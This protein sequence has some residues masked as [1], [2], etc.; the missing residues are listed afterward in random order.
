MSLLGC[1]YWSLWWRW[2]CTVSLLTEGPTCE[3]LG[4]FWMLVCGDYV[5]C[6]LSV[7]SFL[8][9]RKSCSF[10]SSLLLQ[11]TRNITPHSL[12]YVWPLTHPRCCAGV[13]PLPPSWW[14]WVLLPPSSPSPKMPQTPSSH[15]AP[16]WTEGTQTGLLAA[17]PMPSLDIVMSNT[18]YFWITNFRSI[19]WIKAP[20]SCHS[21]ISSINTMYSS[22]VTTIT[23]HCQRPLQVPSWCPECHGC[24]RPGI[25]HV[26]H[27]R[28]AALWRP[29]ELLF[30]RIHPQPWGLQ[31]G[32]LWTWDGSFL[33]WQFSSY[34]QIQS[35]YSVLGLTIK[36][37]F[38]NEEGS[39]VTRTWETYEANFDTFF[40][41][42]LTLLEV[43]TFEGAMP[44]I[45]SATDATV[46]GW[47][48][49]D[50]EDRKL[51][52]LQLM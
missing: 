44:I 26:R 5:L 25:F 49:V 38:A 30:W 34:F 18:K 51:I 17:M 10:A 27:P 3:T 28:H 19:P 1:S 14:W 32:R 20:F 39:N 23:A 46:G 22:A 37:F 29:A 48:W 16:P 43:S 7:F 9:F 52:L 21:I 15:Q 6:S 42:M 33:R 12:F 13:S 41:S 35:Q 4:T 8:S 47:Q 2:L 11:E 45:W 36:G 50:C 31:G 24:R 40:T